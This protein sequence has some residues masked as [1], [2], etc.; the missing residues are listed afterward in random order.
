MVKAEQE[1]ELVNCSVAT[2]YM[3]SHTNNLQMHT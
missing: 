3:L 2:A 1:V